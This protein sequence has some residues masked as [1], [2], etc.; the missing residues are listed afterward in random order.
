MRRIFMSVFDDFTKLQTRQLPVEKVER[1]SHDSRMVIP[2]ENARD[3][4][5]NAITEALVERYFQVKPVVTK[6]NI[7]VPGGAVAVIAVS[8]LLILTGLA[9]YQVPAVLL[10]LI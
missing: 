9:A 8:S 1:L 7:T 10:V 2:S 3:Y 4:P 6:P 5:S